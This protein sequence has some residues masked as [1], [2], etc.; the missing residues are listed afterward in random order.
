[1]FGKKDKEATPAK[2]DEGVSPVKE[3]EPVAEKPPQ[4]DPVDTAVPSDTTKAVAPSSESMDKPVASPS[5]KADKTESK[6]GLRGLFKTREPEVCRPPRRS[7]HQQ[8][9]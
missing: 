5:P 3:T 8:L 9:M 2:K 7:G 6:G 4:L 1:M